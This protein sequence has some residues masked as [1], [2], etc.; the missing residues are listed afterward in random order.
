MDINIKTE[1]TSVG[2]KVEPKTL[3]SLFNCIVR[4]LKNNDRIVSVK[5]DNR[6]K[7]ANSKMRIV[8]K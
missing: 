8:S 1:K 6:S 5:D 2:I 4:A 3:V 7:H